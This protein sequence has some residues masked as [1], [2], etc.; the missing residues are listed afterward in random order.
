MIPSAADVVIVYYDNIA[1]P[2]AGQSVAVPMRFRTFY[3]LS[4]GTDVTYRSGNS[5]YLDLYPV[6]VGTVDAGSG[7]IV[8]N[9]DGFMAQ[10]SNEE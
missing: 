9:K 3:E 8:S 6:L 4:N 1:A 7:G 5:G 10:I 2:A